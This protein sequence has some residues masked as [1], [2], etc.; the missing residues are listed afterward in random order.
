MKYRTLGYSGAYV[1]PICLGTQQFGRW[2][3]EKGAHE[4]LNVFTEQGGNFLDSA[5]CYPIYLPD[6]NEGG[7]VSEII[8]G[9]WLK[10]YARRDDLII[11]TKFSAPMGKGPNSE[12]LSRKHIIKAV[13]QSLKRLG[14]DYIDLYQAHDDYPNVPMEEI[15]RALDDLVTQGLV[16]YIGC[17]NF[18]AWRLMKSLGLC[19]KHNYV[20][21]VTVQGKYN[22]LDRAEYECE[23]MD[24]C[25]EERIGMLPYVPLA[26]GFLT[27]KY[28]QDAPKIQSLRADDVN[29]L[30]NSDKSWK[31]LQL[32]R[33]IAG[34]NAVSCTQVALVWLLQRPAVIS[35]VVGVNSVEQLKEV[36]GAIDVF[37]PIEDMVELN[38]C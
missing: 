31:I 37:L 35:P 3:D 18:P 32:I 14:T 16:R 25:Q 24:L 7:Q 29:K 15:H 26:K 12:G 22:L 21:Y 19:A 33:D 28:H 10:S 17:S 4:I 6:D 27:G 5:D 20:S 38:R 1:S 9:R 11:A 8:I 36:L 2:V 13:E 34:R 30:Y 23:M